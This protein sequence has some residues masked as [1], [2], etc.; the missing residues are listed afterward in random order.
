[1]MR[2]DGIRGAGSEYDDDDGEGMMPGEAAA[3]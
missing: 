3:A 1:M 2:G